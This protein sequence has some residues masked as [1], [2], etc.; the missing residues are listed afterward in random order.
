MNLK[1][2]IEAVITAEDSTKSDGEM[3]MSGDGDGFARK[4]L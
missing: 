3:S 1:L 4:Q 2:F